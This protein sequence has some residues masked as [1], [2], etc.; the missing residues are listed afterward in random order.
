MAKIARKIS[1]FTRNDL[2]EEEDISEF[3]LIHQEVYDRPFE[4]YTAVRDLGLQNGVRMGLGW[5]VNG[6]CLASLRLKRDCPR[7]FTEPRTSQM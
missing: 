1:R 4:V 5:G 6:T 3:D 7:F 2:I